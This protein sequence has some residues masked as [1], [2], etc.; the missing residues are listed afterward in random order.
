MTNDIID[1]IVY[2]KMREEF[3]KLNIL[4][5]SSYI[6]CDVLIIKAIIAYT[7]EFIKES[8]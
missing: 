7:N 8:V 2:I 5:E 6:W 4:Q 1:V 3:I